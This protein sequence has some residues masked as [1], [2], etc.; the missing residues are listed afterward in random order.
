MRFRGIADPQLELPLNG[1]VL[2]LL[3]LA[4]FEQD[5][6]APLPEFHGHYVLI[7]TL[8]PMVFITFEDQF[9]IQPDL[10]G[11]LAAES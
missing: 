2:F 6:V 9:S 7:D 8:S 3:V 1:P 5:R 10:P 11:V 4:E